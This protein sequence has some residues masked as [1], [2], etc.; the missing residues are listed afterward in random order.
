MAASPNS[1][2]PP[3]ADRGPTA[4]RIVLGSH[5]R[6]LRERAGIRRADAAYAIRGSDSKLSRLEAG[7]VGFKQRDVLDLLTLYGV[8][9]GPEREQVIAMAGES[10]GSGWW[11][12][13]NDVVPG[14]FEGFVGLESSASRILTYELMFV[15]GLLQTEAYCRA[16]VSGGHAD[17]P[18]D[19]RAEVE[20]RVEVRLR[21]QKVLHR[22]DA[23]TFWVVLDEAVLWRPVGGRA[24]YR[25]QI[26]HLL[27]LSAL[28]NVVVQLLP[29]SLSGYAA[30]HAFTML[31]FAEP[32]L[33]DLVYLEEMTGAS[34]LDKRA[35][36]ER[37][38]RS[39][40]RLTV[41]ALSPDET[42]QALKKLLAEH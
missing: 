32:E 27:D 34:Y 7:K 16:V 30:E 33:P 6:R 20:K 31:R 23:P 21:R 40:D 42:G 35:D 29:W 19:R 4:Q 38:G 11:T 39:M 13:Y 37:Y 12:R 5:L 10:K 24:V 3:G 1:P 8:A 22:K 9:D 2:T 28:P 18:P 41:D 15:P 25:E 36:V 17:L 26:E 14:W